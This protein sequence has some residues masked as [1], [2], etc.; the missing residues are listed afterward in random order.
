MKLTITE[1]TVHEEEQ[2]P[3]FGEFVTRVKLEDNA[4]GFFIK[5][6]QPESPHGVSLG[7]DEIDSIVEAIN[8]LKKQVI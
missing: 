7:F 3:V 2:H 5:L 8:I 1:I 4:A 6:E